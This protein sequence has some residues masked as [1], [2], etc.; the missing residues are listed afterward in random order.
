MIKLV[1]HFNL[2]EEMVLSLS[3]D[4]L[5]LAL[6]LGHQ[7]KWIVVHVGVVGLEGVAFLELSVSVA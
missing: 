5:C 1:H 2:I 4:R 7:L 3:F 6:K